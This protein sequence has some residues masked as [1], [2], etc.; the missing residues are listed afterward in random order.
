MILVWSRSGTMATTC[1][2]EQRAPY[3]TLAGGAGA[4]RRR[5]AALVSLFASYA[6][7]AELQSWLERG[8]LREIA[9][10]RVAVRHAAPQGEG[11][12]RTPTLRC[13]ATRPHVRP[14]CRTRCST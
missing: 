8:W 2:A 1:S 7:T 13:S 5:C 12:P 9:A 14:G 11:R 6:R 3:P 4:A 10:D